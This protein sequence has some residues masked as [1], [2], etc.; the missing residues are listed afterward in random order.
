MHIRHARLALLALLLAIGAGS[1]GVVSADSPAPSLRWT[2]DEPDGTTAIDSTGGGNDGVLVGSP[3]RLTGPV[4]DGTGAVQ[5]D[6]IDDAVTIASPTGLDTASFTV[7]FWL[8][9]SV[10]P[11]DG[12][13]ILEKGALGCETGS[14]RVFAQ[15]PYIEAA[16]FR[17]DGSQYPVSAQEYPWTDGRWHHFAWTSG[18]AGAGG[19]VMYI[20]GVGAQYTDPSSIRYSGL[21]SSALSVGQSTTPGHCGHQG[22]A[23]S[24]DDLRM[25][26]RALSQPEVGALLPPIATTTSVTLPAN[27]DVGELVTAHVTI[28]GE[29]RHGRVDLVD[30]GD[31]SETTLNSNYVFGGETILAAS[32]PYGHHRIRADYHDGLPWVPSSSA[33]VELVVDRKPTMTSIQRPSFGPA[34]PTL[35]ISFTA[36]TVFEA[37]GQPWTLE[38]TVSIWETT[39]GAAVLVAG[40]NAPYDRDFIVAGHPAGTYTFEARFE[41]D[42]YAAPSS[43]IPYELLVARVPTYM[44]MTLDPASPREHQTARAT[45]HVAPSDP[46]MDPTGTVVL[47]EKGSGRILVTAAARRS[48]TVTVPALRRGRHE[49]VARYSGSELIAPA[50][51]T[52]V[53]QV[54]RDIVEADRLGVTASTFYPVVDSFRDTVGI[55]GR[56]LERASVRADIYAGSGAKVRTLSLSARKGTYSMTWNGK[57]TAGSLLP[58]GSYR[59]VQTLRDTAG[60]IRTATSTVTLSTKRISWITTTITVDGE[61]YAASGRQ[62]GG[63]VSTGA[64]SYSRGVKI[65]GNDGW[66]A[67]GYRFTLPAAS[68]Y[69]APKFSVYG[70]SAVM[71]ETIGIQ[72]W[73]TCPSAT[74]WD[75]SCFDAWSGIGPISKWYATSAP[76]AS[77]VNTRSVRGI[78]RS[79]YSF[80]DIALARVTI[81]YGVLR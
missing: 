32:L 21:D 80:A 23:I 67:V 75:E 61:D 31:T 20:D 27:V 63:T 65:Q 59:I 33:I 39:S 72:N 34:I 58:G 73:E 70:H 74:T 37:A 25:Y 41:G 3:V 28:T 17:P 35:P 43:S 2:L 14:Y 49:L 9:S 4:P 78:V 26:P 40:P 52:L 30:V 15:G 54:R 45:V 5:L 44:D 1:A 68:V 62:G 81:T 53:V 47:E 51:S 60:T 76:A 42:D 12:A 66:A 13:I 79:Q 48:F 50:T 38:G 29:P 69:K 46:D 19:P 18:E 22:A 8:K 64:S 56:L 71:P 10:Q 57:S 6:G 16:F 7:A 36:D 55:K 11:A 24:I 77:H